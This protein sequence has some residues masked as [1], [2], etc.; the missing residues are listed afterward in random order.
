MFSVGEL[1]GGPD[2]AVGRAFA[3]RRHI[4]ISR[5][6]DT[7]LGEPVTTLLALVPGCS[8]ITKDALSPGTVDDGQIASFGTCE[9]NDR[10]IGIVSW[11]DPSDQSTP[12]YGLLE[13]PE[14]YWFAEGDGWKMVPANNPTIL[15]TLVGD[16]NWLLQHNGEPPAVHDVPG[17][18]Q[19]AD[20]VVAALG[21]TATHVTP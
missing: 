7:H 10:T 11:G 6:C 4:T 19:D 2:Y 18:K 16:L 14:E 17:E 20:T 15:R 8:N 9:L 3:D 1:A 13:T 5:A 21:G 12:P